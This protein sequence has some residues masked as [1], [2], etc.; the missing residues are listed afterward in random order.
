MATK[1]KAKKP[2]A[3]NPG[4][5]KMLT[6]GKSGVGKT[7]LSMDFPAPYYVD[8]EGGARLAHYQRK[9][10]ESGGAY[11][12]IDDGALDFDAVIGQVEALATERH[13]YKTLAF[14]SITKLYQSA[15]AAEQ[16]RLG[17]RDQFGA[18][19]KPAI[20]YMRRLISWI[21]R[22]D[23]NV[24]FE[25]HEAVEWGQNPKTGQR[26]EIGHAP[27]VWDKLV[28]ELDLT[29]RIEKR[30]PQRLCQVR[31]SR[32]TGFQEGEAFSCEYSEFGT[33]YGKDFIEAAVIPIQLATD[34]QV[35]EINRLLTVVNV[36]EKELESALSRAKAETVAE[37][38]QDY[39][40]K[41]IEWLKK[42]V[43]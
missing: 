16:Q 14:G 18:S 26:E 38:S 29:L 41:F 4:K 15:I 32:L 24:L 21:H 35:A 25:A 11:F 10:S 2:E 13:D 3:V 8:C 36:S 40:A 34:L 43:A 37:L 1:L 9:L 5:I 28:Y 19:K 12:G 7:W 20:A 23:M 17:D 42:K 27:D 22:I 6:Y 39:A 30:G 33:R 31:K